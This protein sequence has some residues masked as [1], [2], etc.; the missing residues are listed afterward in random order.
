[1]SKM[2][3]FFDKLHRKLESG[4]GYKSRIA[5][6]ILS[7]AIFGAFLFPLWKIKMYAPQYPKGLWIEIY[8]Y[9]LQGGNKGQHIKEINELN[10]YI[11]MREIREED[12]AELDWIPFAL[13]FLFIWGLRVALIG[14]V[15]SLVDLT[16]MTIYFSLFSFA[17]FIYHLYVLGH[18]LSPDAAIKIKPFMPVI[19]GKKQIANFTTY[20]YPLLGSLFLGIFALGLLYISIYH[21]W[22]KAPTTECEETEE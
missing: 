13:G 5:I 7:F 9:K 21:L 22:K 18:H 19:I 1:M 10:H 16:V 14:N 4:I 12:L 2:A 11:G 15:R 6:F 8:A 17:R 20:S 3:K